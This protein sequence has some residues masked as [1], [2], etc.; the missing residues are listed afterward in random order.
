M[1]LGEEQAT[2][3]LAEYEVRLMTAVRNNFEEA[4]A[5]QN[6]ENVS[7]FAKLFYP[8]GLETEGIM[9]YIDFIRFSLVDQ[10]NTS[11]RTLNLGRSN[12][13]QAQVTFV[14]VVMK[15]FVSIADIVQEHQRHVEE[16][17]GGSNFL[18]FLRGL[19]EEADSLTCRVL[20][21]FLQRKSKVLSATSETIDTREA[22]ATLEEMSFLCQRCQ[23]F[24]AYLHNTAEDLK[25]QRDVQSKRS[26]DSKARSSIQLDG[27]GLPPRLPMKET[28]KS[29]I[30]DGFGPD[31]LVVES[32]LVRKVQ[33]VVARMVGLEGVWMLA[34][35]NNAV[36]SDHVDIDDED[37]QTYDF[38][39]GF[40]VLGFDAVTTT[41]AARSQLTGCSNGSL[42]P[43]FFHCAAFAKSAP[44]VAS[45][46][47]WV[48]F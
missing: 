46:K 6:T 11:F 30:D 3:V 36:E 35:I 32:G 25:R 41:G 14:E 34:Q 33:E 10:C 15:V 13:G 24:E 9:R 4:I 18:L 7:R 47:I 8:L 23:E 2:K 19:Q 27:F 44:C 26:A 45:R 20:D 39:F 5:Q 1:D 28:T 40:S 42:A 12:E 43:E 17:F 16:E 22:D 21:L 38:D 37:V 31:G 48:G 29:F